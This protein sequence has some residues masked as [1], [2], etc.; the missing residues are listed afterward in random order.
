LIIENLKALRR[1]KGWT[2]KKTAYNLEIGLCK[3]QSYEEGRAEPKIQ[4]LIQISD[5]YEISIDR[6]VKEEI[7]LDIK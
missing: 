3:Y 2:Q 1:K 5:L 7:K 6:L 4:L